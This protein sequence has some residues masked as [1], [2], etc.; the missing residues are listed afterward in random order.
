[1]DK[2]QGG[3]ESEEVDTLNYLRISELKVSLYDVWSL[4]S[5]T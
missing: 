5:L 1:V 2:R 4:I 3:I